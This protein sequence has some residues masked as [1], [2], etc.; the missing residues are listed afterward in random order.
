MHVESPGPLSDRCVLVTGITDEASL[1]LPIARE[2]RR[3]GAR[4]LC[5]GLGPQHAPPE[6]S[7]R[8]LD[9]LRSSFEGF[10][11]TVE[12]ELGADVPTLDCNVSNDESLASL[13]AAL[14][15]L[16]VCVDGVVHAV[17]FDRTIRGDQSP[18]LIDTPRDAFLECMNVSAYSM[19]ALTRALLETGRLSGG[20][21]LVALSY[22]GA[23]RSVT[24]PYR[25]VGVAKAALERIV[26]EL[27]VELGRDRQTR[28]NAIRFSPYSAS[29]AGG[30]I[31]G[32]S[33][34]EARANAQSPLGNASPDALAYEVCHLLRRGVGI[35]GEI[36]HVDGGY[37]VLG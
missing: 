18:R 15:D 34:A 13:G 12:A 27:A 19:I 16:D 31:P 33:D 1:A 10:R 2:I 37:H 4:L 32:L 28:V 35:T 5:T 26:T 3:Q 17:A 21:S 20:A 25:N 30:A 6:T 36:R 23:E 22:I 7:E 14:V 8:A 24:H 29:R 11:K 9:H